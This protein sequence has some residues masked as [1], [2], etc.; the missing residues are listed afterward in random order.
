MEANEENLAIHME[1]RKT[2]EWMKEWKKEW[3]VRER[4][5][6]KF[7]AILF[8]CYMLDQA[9]TDCFCVPNK[10]LGPKV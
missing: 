7:Q 3:R 8:T 2:N 6:K 9:R 5:R 4:N 1:E 10:A